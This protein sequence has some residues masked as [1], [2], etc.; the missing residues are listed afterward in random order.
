MA[1]A[2]KASSS[3]IFFL[4]KR[5]IIRAMNVTVARMKN[6][7]GTP[8]SSGASVSSVAIVAIAETK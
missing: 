7:V 3:P 1:A 6:G 8:T 4:R 2:R 5:M